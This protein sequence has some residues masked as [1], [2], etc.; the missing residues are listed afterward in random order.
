VQITWDPVTNI[1]M[2][3]QAFLILRQE[4]LAIIDTQTNKQIGSFSRRAAHVA[5]RSRGWDHA[6]SWRGR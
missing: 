5:S 3:E 2:S 4:Q 6:Y 1:F